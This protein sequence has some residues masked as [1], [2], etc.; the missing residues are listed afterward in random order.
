MST[1]IGICGG[2]GSGKSTLATKVAAAFAP[3]AVSV[4]QFD[5]YYRDHSHLSP[6]E[7]AKVNYD[8]PDSLDVELFIDH[9]D[10]LRSGEAVPTPVYDFASHTRSD[11]VIWLDPTP[12]LVVEG[13]LLLA[14]E[15]IRKRFELSVFRECPEDIRL[16]RR[17]QRDIAERGRTAQS[18][19]EQFAT[20]VGPMHDEFVD[21]FAVTAD[22]V[23]KH[24]EMELDDAALVV[25]EHLKKL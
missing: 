2:S 16:A 14:F 21:P 4:L 17:M 23:L 7:R 11:K 18:V 20:T 8:H 5:S 1:V 22:L 10:T 9:L 13:I 15:D 6:D 24:G 19:L 12:H 3:S 25:L